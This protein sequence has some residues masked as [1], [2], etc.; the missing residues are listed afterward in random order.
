MTTHAQQL[1]YVFLDFFRR[2]AVLDGN[3]YHTDILITGNTPLKCGKRDDN[4][5]V[6]VRS[7]TALSFSLQD[8]DYLAG[9]LFQA[10]IFSQGILSAEQFLNHRLSHNTDRRAAARLTFRELPA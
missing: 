10:D 7:H 6:L 9:N 3:L 2:D 1:F 8:A 5:I 4:D